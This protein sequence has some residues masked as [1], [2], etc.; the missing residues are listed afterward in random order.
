MNTRIHGGYG[1]FSVILFFLTAA[2][3]IYCMCL[4]KKGI[5]LA[6]SC[7]KKLR[8]APNF[9]Q[10]GIFSQNVP[11][12]EIMNQY[13][14]TTYPHKFLASN[15]PNA[16]ITLNNL[17]FCPTFRFSSYINYFVNFHQFSCI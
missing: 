6:F 13:Y 17:L 5:F 8:S 1:F 12:F 9:K 16:N 4:K 2:K 10:M 11:N 7:S 14:L 3:S 15:G